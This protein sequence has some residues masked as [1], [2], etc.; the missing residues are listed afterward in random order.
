MGV[1]LTS[2]DITK[3]ALL[4]LKAKGFEVWRQ[5]QV[6]VPGRGFVGKKGLSDIIG[7]DGSGRFVFCEVKKKGDRLSDDQIQLLNKASQ[8]GCLCYIA[9]QIN[10]SVELSE[11]IL[12]N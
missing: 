8:S 12:E 10:D 1:V 4:R 11:Y 9:K 6:K 7:F 2:N 5:N 3:E